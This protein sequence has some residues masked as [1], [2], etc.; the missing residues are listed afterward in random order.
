MSA[1]TEN[2]TYHYKVDGI[3]RSFVMH[4]PLGLPNNAP[5]VFVLHGY[6]GTANPNDYDLDDVADKNKFAICYPQGVKDGQGKTC[7]NVGYPFQQDMK[8]DDVNFLCE[9]AKHLQKTFHLSS[10]NTFCT[11][12]SNGGEMCYLLAYTRPDVFAA[13]API[14]GLTMEWVYRKYDCPNPIPLFEVHG[15]EDRVSEWMGDLDNKG[16][17]GAY[18]PIPVAIGY[19]VAKNRC[20]QEVIDTL[21]VKNTQN[22]H[23]VITHKYINGIDGHEVWLYQVVNGTHCWSN[24]DLNTGEEI[25]KFFRKFIK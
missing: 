16:G 14:S 6:T 12:M 20:T 23:Y 8:I 17:W 2:K 18:L 10:K 7:W 22:G 15:T 4:L 25:W 24:V 3:D 13:V 9:L 11:G 5:L 1:A 21:P 19:W